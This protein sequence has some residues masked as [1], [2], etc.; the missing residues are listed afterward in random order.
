MNDKMSTY[1]LTDI[2]KDAQEK[3]FDAI[4]LLT[5]YVNETGDSN[6]KAYI[7]DHL[8]IMASRDHNFL[9]RDVNIDD[10]VDRVNE[11]GD[12]DE[13]DEGNW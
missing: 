6:A 5:T 12:Y 13:G 3:L 11:A 4:E 9:S 10:L 1:E 2:L 7:V 8:K